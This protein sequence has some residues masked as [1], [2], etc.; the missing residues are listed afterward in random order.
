M[1]T[2]PERGGQAPK[3]PVVVAY[4]RHINLTDKPDDYDPPERDEFGGAAF[5]QRYDDPRA[6]LDDHVRVINI[7]F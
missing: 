1:A 6:W 2:V 3:A 4:V 5:D 7:G